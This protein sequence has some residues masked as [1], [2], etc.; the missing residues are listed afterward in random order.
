MAKPKKTYEWKDPSLSGGIATGVMVLNILFLGGSLAFNLMTGTAGY[1]DANEANP[2]QLQSIHALLDVA[3]LPMLLLAA[4][5]GFWVV[6]VSKNA[7]SGNPS[8]KMSPLGAIGWYIVPVAFLFKPFQAMEEIWRVSAGQD[9]QKEP[10]L[11]WWWG[12]LLASSIIS[13]VGAK[14]PDPGAS[15]VLESLHQ[16]A[17]VATSILLIVMIR[18]L[19]AMQRNMKGVWEVFDDEAPRSPSVLEGLNA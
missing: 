17:G 16:A 9:F 14:F 3:V 10:L 7:H 19:N 8:M 2:T 6:R 13:T 11:N 18:R 1:Y 4:L 5:A 12:C 15:V